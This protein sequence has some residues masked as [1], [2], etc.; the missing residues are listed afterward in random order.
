MGRANFSNVVEL[1]KS[2]VTDCLTPLCTKIETAL[3]RKLFLDRSDRKRYFFRFDFGE[4][5]RAK[6]LEQM[7]TVQLGRMTG[8]LTQNEARAEINR[9]PVPGGDTFLSPLNMTI[10]GKPDGATD[11]AIQYNPDSDAD[12]SPDI[13]ED[14]D[15]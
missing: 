10:T 2:Y 4:M 1:N 13:N 14:L 15:T 9:N 7:Q 11:M 5:L 12:V 3:I 8:I 6:E